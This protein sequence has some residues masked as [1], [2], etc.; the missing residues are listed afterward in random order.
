M[1]PFNIYLWQQADSIVH[2]ICFLAVSS[3]VISIAIAIWTCIYEKGYHESREEFKKR[4]TDDV[5]HGVYMLWRAVPLTIF[6]WGLYALLPSSKSIA[7]IVALPAIANSEPIQKDLPEI[8][9][10]AKD[11]LKEQLSSK[12]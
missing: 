10:L 3:T 6:T 2:V 7:L 12:P 5:K 4:R 1:T 11:A 9:K 8:Y